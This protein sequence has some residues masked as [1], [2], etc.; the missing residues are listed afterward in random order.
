M[1]EESRRGGLVGGLT[2]REEERL[3]SDE[4]EPDEKLYFFGVS[5][6]G[7]TPIA[8]CAENLPLP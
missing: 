3:K 8:L 4:L 1:I 6:V 2:E 5:M 7:V